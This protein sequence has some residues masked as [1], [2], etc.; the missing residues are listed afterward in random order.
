MFVGAQTY[1]EACYPRR[2]GR[3]TSE[4]EAVRGED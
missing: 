1:D 3:E 4:E 2:G